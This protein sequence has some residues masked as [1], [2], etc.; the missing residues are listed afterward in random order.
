MKPHTSATRKHIKTQETET[1]LVDKKT[2]IQ[3]AVARVALTTGKMNDRFDPVANRLTKMASKRVDSRTAS[4]SSHA[5]VK[6]GNALLNTPDKEGKLRGGKYENDLATVEPM[7]TWPTGDGNEKV[8]LGV[9][10]S[11]DYASAIVA[12]R[13][14][15]THGEKQTTKVTLMGLPYGDMRSDPSRNGRVDRTL[16]AVDVTNL[17]RRQKADGHVPAV[18]GVV[19]SQVRG[20]EGTDNLA[21]LH[22]DFVVR[23]DGKYG[24]KDRNTE[25]GTVVLDYEAFNDGTLGDS[26]Y[27]AAYRLV[28]DLSASPEL[29]DTSAPVETVGEYE[30]RMP[31]FN[32]QAR[33]QAV[34][35]QAEPVHQPYHHAQ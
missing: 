32:R 2:R 22:Y 29:W 27:R 26:D 24:I 18:A 11:G 31:R 10:L 30:F 13:Q 25:H 35:Q 4:G 3:R 16:A 1:P 12:S 23:A 21:K 34:Q 9:V 7:I 20:L 19:G 6:I 28:S 8:V 5:L 14:T 15:T 33:E 17:A